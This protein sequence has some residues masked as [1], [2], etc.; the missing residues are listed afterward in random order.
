MEDG[1][2]SKC[3]YDRKTDDPVAGDLVGT[4]ITKLLKY[5]ML[6]NVTESLVRF[7]L[8]DDLRNKGYT[9]CL[10]ISWILVTQV[11]IRR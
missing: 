4:D 1:R 6:R 7:L 10:D 11:D 2:N 3:V 9:R 8:W 5:T